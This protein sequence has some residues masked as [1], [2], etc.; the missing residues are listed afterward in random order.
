MPYTNATVT[1]VAQCVTSVSLAGDNN[2]TG[3]MIHNDSVSE[4]QIQHAQ[5]RRTA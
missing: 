1:R 3:V 4:L 2:R 5:L